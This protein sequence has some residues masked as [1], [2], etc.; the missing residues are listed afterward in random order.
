MPDVYICY[1]EIIRKKDLQ[2]NNFKIKLNINKK[3][4]HLKLFVVIQ[5][6]KKTNNKKSYK[7]N[8]LQINKLLIFSSIK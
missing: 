3:N 1:L 5:I 2:N 7:F 8:K 6:K 4:S